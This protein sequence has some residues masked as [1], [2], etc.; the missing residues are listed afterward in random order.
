MKNQE[1]KLLIIE[2]FINQYT[3]NK[4]EQNVM[5]ANAKEYVENSTNELLDFIGDKTDKAELIE[6]IQDI[7]KEWGSF[8]TFDINADS[9]VSIPVIGNHIH[10][11]NI[12]NFDTV[13][14]E[15]YEDGGDNEID[16]YDLSYYDMDVETLNEIL[17]YC[18]N[19]EADNLQTEKRISN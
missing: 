15:V 18:E 12:F 6:K 17:T 16:S 5:K 2:N 8:S 1:R 9:D 10:L 7:I 4:K 11:A 13:N 3:S 19:W 14:V